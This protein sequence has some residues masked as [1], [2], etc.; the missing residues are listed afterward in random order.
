[1][2]TILIACRT[3][4]SEITAAVK[5]T[6]WNNKILWL[7]SGLH[8]KPLELH[9][10][11][12]KYIDSCQEY[13]RILLAM[14]SCGNSIFGLNTG[15]TELVFPRVDDCITLL[16]GSR[17]KRHDYH[18]SYFFTEGWLKGERTIWHEYQYTLDKYD[19]NTAQIVLDTMLGHYKSCVFLDTHCGNSSRISAHIK[20]IAKS[21][22]LDYQ[23]VEGTLDYICKLLTGPWDKK[24]FAVIPPE[25]TITYKY[26]L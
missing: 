7:K 8:E 2:S 13:D 10:I 24:S 21:L 16:C 17:Q 11:L 1:M 25:T 26:F 9:N 19:K 15:R 20:E 3:L 6:N 22:N 14:G 23:I 4:E 5:R 12:Q 18:Q